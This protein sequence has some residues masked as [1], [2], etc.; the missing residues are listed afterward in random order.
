[1]DCPKC[2]S[3]M[4]VTTFQQIAVNKCS[5][6]DGLWFD[7]LEHELLRDIKGANALDTG[8]PSD[9]AMNDMITDYKCPNCSGNMVKLVDKEQPHIW[10]EVC[11]ACYGVYFDAGEFRD[12]AHYSFFDFVAQFL[13]KERA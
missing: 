9:G 8:D 6:C 4:M 1:M 11:H 2:S 7:N 3:T 12:Y 13:N 10:Y 5:G